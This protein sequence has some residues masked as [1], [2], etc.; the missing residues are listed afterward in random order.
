MNDMLYTDQS[1][2]GAFNLAPGSATATYVGGGAVDPNQSVIHQG[3]WFIHKHLKNI[4][5]DFRLSK[6]IFEG[7]TLTAGLYLAH[8]TMDDD[9]DLGNQMLMTNTP[10]ASPITVSYVD[11]NGVNQ[12]TGRAPYREKGV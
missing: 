4:N 3:W 9:C 5:N 11:T 2:I 12:P 10:N 6:E 8:Y 1:Q 7:N